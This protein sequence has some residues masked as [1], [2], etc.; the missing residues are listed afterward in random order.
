MSPGTFCAEQTTRQIESWS[1]K[2]AVQMAHEIVERHRARPYGF[3]FETRIVAEPVPDGEGGTLRVE[4]KTVEKSGIYFLD[5]IIETLA[6]VE[7][8]STPKDRILIENMRCNHYDRIVTTRNGY[9]WCQPFN[10]GDH[11]VNS[12]TGEVSQ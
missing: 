9:S 5:G 7:A 4:P 2:L 10:D 11:V 8:R 3:R 12:Q 1:T 6:D